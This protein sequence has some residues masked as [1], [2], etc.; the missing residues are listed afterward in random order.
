MRTGSRRRSDQKEQDAVRILGIG[1]WR[2]RAR[3]REE[4][5]KI[6]GDQMG[7]QQHT[8]VPGLPPP[9]KTEFFR[10]TTD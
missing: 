1:H 5:R 2:R 3:N 8:W 6:L 9:W 7:L 4:K 10:A